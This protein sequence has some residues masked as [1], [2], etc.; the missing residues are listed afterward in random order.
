[1]WLNVGGLVKLWVFEGF[2]S[3]ESGSEGPRILRF[4]WKKF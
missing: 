3:P 4:V 2:S 1:M